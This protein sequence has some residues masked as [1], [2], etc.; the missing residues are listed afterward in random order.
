MRVL[1]TNDDGIAAPGLLALARAAADAG[2]QVVV[3]APDAER[4]GASAALT[5]V[6]DEGRIVVARH[7]LDGLDE[8]YAVGGSP[9]F[10][11]WLAAGGAFGNPPDAVLSG[12]NR[13]A[14]A[15]RAVLHSGTVGAALTA[16][17]AG[18]P[19]VAVS[20]DVLTAAVASAGSGGAAVRAID[21]VDDAARHWATAAR[22]GVG[23][24]TALVP[25]VVF[26]VNTPDVPYDRLRGVRRA[27]LSRFGQVQMTVVEAGEGFVRTTV[28]ATGDRPDPGT[29]LAVL[30]DGY[31]SVTALRGLA[32]LSDVEL[33]GVD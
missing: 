3:A 14:N 31:A 20:L 9:A 33:P 24:L 21:R 27:G 7:T 13:G 15:G 23:L 12:V 16:A 2:H 25:G 11:A 28:E 17:A 32:E 8:A 4:S 10:I 22:V 30:A 18:T 5:A 19:G 29:D 26:N 1:V 6:E